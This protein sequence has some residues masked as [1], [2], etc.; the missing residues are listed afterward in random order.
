MYS[1]LWFISFAWSS[2]RK[3]IVLL[4]FTMQLLVCLWYPVVVL[5]FSS[6]LSY[7]QLHIV[8]KKKKTISTL[9]TVYFYDHQHY[10]FIVECRKENACLRNL[11][12][13][14]GKFQIVSKCWSWSMSKRVICHSWL[15]GSWK[16]YYNSLF[17][18]S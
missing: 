6:F 18:T 1:K 12:H 16:R 9:L 2:F 14:I 8:L 3:L 4:F 7:L 17:L 5:Y 10:Q 15:F 11:I 13:H